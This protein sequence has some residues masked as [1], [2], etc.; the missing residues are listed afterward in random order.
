M[1]AYDVTDLFVNAILIFFFLFPHYFKIQIVGLRN[2]I[3]IVEN[4]QFDYGKSFYFG[5]IVILLHILVIVRSV[6]II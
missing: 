6:I 3:L 4:L 2:I 5:L 1:T